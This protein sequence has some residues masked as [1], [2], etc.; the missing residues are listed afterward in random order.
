MKRILIT[1]AL[2]A[3]SFAAFAQTTAPGGRD[4]YSQG[5]R[6]TDPRDPYTQGARVGDSR[7]PYTQGA[8]ADDKFDPYTQGANQ[9]VRTDLAPGATDPMK[10]MPMGSMPSDRNVY[11]PG[12]ETPALGTRTGGRNQFL[13]G[14]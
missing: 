6:T 10:P 8:R 14:A 12:M 13:D 2:C 7:D 5:A 3:A 1:A 11:R 4:P 9:S